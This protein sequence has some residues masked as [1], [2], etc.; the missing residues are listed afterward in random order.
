MVVERVQQFRSSGVRTDLHELDTKH[1]MLDAATIETVS[2]V[3]DDPFEFRLV[4]YTRT[5]SEHEQSRMNT[6]LLGRP[7]V[8]TSTVIGS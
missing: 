8:I 4:G 7:S 1:V 2:R 3:D 6:D 5:V